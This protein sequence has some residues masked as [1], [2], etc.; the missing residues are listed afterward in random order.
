VAR[1]LI[2]EDGPELTNEEIDEDEN[3][4]EIR[5]GLSPKAQ[6]IREA[7]RTACAQHSV[8]HCLRIH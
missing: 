2:L 4:D 8:F 1:Q 7:S 6:I 3:G 5:D